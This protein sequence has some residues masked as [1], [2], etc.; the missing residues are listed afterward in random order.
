MFPRATWLRLL[1]AA[2]FEA[3]E[4]PSEHSEVEAGATFVYLGHRPDARH[5]TRREPED[6]PR[7]FQSWVLADTDAA[8]CAIVR[9][10]HERATM[11]DIHPPD[12]GPPVPS[13]PVDEPR[14]LSDRYRLTGHLARGGMADVFQAEDQLLGRTVAIKI[15]HPQ[16]VGTKPSLPASGARR[17]P[18]PT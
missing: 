5:L 18:P 11:T 17:W 7:A 4:V 3:T 16:F 9:Q 13:P 14:V 1:T 2:G 6:H 12:S 8:C 10:K 15:L